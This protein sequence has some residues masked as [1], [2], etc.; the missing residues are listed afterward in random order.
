[1]WILIDNDTNVVYI[2]SNNEEKHPGNFYKPGFRNLPFFSTAIHT[3]F[4]LS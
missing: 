1:M 4:K 3:I 2:L